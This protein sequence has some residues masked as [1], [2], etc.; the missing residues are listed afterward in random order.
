MRFS[1]GFVR[2]DR[3]CWALTASVACLLAVGCAAPGRLGWAN[4]KSDKATDLMAADDSFPS[5]SEAGL[6]MTDQPG[7]K[8]R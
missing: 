3:T 6:A 1:C 8:N 7:K 2:L 5:A 4:F